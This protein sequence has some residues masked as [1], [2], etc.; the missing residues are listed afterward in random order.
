MKYVY[1]ICSDCGNESR[2]QVLTK[3]EREKNPR[4]P[5]Y[6]VTCPKCGSPN[7]EIRD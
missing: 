3:E 4:Q 5:V 6:R 2:V 7:V 1:A